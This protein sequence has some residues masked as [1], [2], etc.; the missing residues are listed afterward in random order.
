MK[1][2]IIGLD[3]GTTNCTLSYVLE[4]SEEI[5]TLA[6]PQY[7]NSGE[8]QSLMSLP[9]FLYFP[10]DEEETEVPFFVGQY[11][12]TRG[13]ELPSRLISSA[14]SWLS[15]TGIDR[16]SPVLP[17]GEGKMSPM[18]ACS[19]FLQHLKAV[20]NETFPKKPFDKQTILIT[21]P[22]SFD[23]SARQFVLEAAELAGYPEPILLEEPLAAL[24]AWIQRQGEKWREEVKVGDLV[25]VVDVGGGTTDFTLVR[26]DESQ[27]D[28]ALN[29]ISVGSHLLLGGDNLD[30]ALAYF[31]KHKLEEEG[32]QLDDWQF[33]QLA[34][35]CRDAKEQL[36]AKN[37]PE[38][39]TISIQ[40]RGSRLI[41]GQIQTVLTQEE[42]SKLILDGF[43]PLSK[44]T[45][46]SETEKRSGL[47]QAG[48]PYAKDPRVSRQLAAFLSQGETFALPSAVLFN[49][50]TL[51]AEGIRGRI[52]EILAGWADELG[53]PSPNIMECV[54]YDLSVSLGAAFYGLVR[55]GKG[56]RIKG[57][58]SRSYFIG[59]EAAAPAVPGVPV[60]VQ[61]VCVAPRGMEEG[62]E[63]SL[64][65][66]FSLIL[67]E[68]VSFRFL[69][70]HDIYKVGQAVE[71]EQQ[72]RLQ[73]HPPI[74][75]ELDRS[76][77]DGRGI[78]VRLKSR[79][80]ELGVL[81][82]WCESTD[83]RKW[84]LNF[85]TRSHDTNAKAVAAS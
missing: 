55:E 46:V 10:L 80:T 60:P 49:G 42:A 13:A 29:R 65:Q 41:G 66:P 39:V 21:V 54:D 15:H 20:W 7:V 8:K 83:G 45:E 53:A 68:P 18:E 62:S 67:G 63:A 69:S 85:D 73:E 1:Q 77:Q 79:V 56:I 31:A 32:Q 48:L 25:L 9:S 72:N 26:V 61:A 37:S 33:G 14:K 3:L 57:G 17:V 4:G 2:T 58:I 84:K 75:T 74:E 5:E 19:A 28:L 38:E 70:H 24:Y 82:L 30:L 47:Y 12:K 52:V 22:A 64:D 6:I 43:F 50:G 40:G 36:F 11:A 78:C 76:D 44:S 35:A 81:E 59:V 51:K 34:H 71:K 27:G 23:P 16:R